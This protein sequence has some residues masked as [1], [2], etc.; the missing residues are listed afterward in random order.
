MR[1][2]YIS[3]LP[4]VRSGIA[5]YSALLLPA[6]AEKFDVVAVVDQD[7]V[8][9]LPVPVIRGDEYERRAGEFD[10]AVCQLGNNRHHELAWKL[11]SRGGAVVVLHDIVMHHLLVE[12][13]LARGDGKSLREALS[14]MYGDAGAAIASARVHGIHD[15]LPNFL[16]PASEGLAQHARHVIVHNRWAAEQLRANG[17]STPITVAPHPYAER[18]APDDGLRR[19]IRQRLGFSP[20]HRV[21]GA[22]G[23]VTHAK[24]PEALMRA[25][26]SASRERDDLRLLFVGEPSHNVDLEAMAAAAGVARDRWASTGFVADEEFDRHIAAVDRVVNLRYPSAGETSGP[27][28]HVFSTG[29][30]VAVS[31]YAQFADFPGAI[32]TRIPFESEIDSLAAFMLAEVD[33][34]RLGEAQR[35]W[36][37]ATSTLQ[38]TVEAYSRAL[39][40]AAAPRCESTASRTMPL[41]L[42]PRLAA[43]IES[44]ERL[45]RSTVVS[46]RIVNEGDATIPSIVFGQPPF[47]L[48]ARALSNGA[49]VAAASAGLSRDLEPGGSAIVPI[50]VECA[51]DRFTLEL[52]H[53]LGGVPDVERPAFFVREVVA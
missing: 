2:A 22:F 5:H 18:P 36:L 31:D 7:E 47:V 9:P 6:L 37:R 12:M 35:T 33:V 15:D 21:I 38:L 49:N 19:A 27:L 29:R 25:F 42:F 52:R 48:F 44:I 11:A 23:F 28:V 24:R 3:P 32:V 16:Y 41:P 17:V 51:L 30:P 53:G 45:D 46:L 34:K 43:S 13:T 10:A 14:S 40:E 50:V 26:A 1:L 8:V 4:P 20:Q 39:A